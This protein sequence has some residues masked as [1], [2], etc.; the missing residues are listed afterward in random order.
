M[1]SREIVRG[2][3]WEMITTYTIKKYLRD[4]VY[5]GAACLLLAASQANAMLITFSDTYNP[6]PDPLIAFGNNSSYTFSHSLIADQDAGASLWSGTYGF[7]F[8]TDTITEAS[9]LMRFRDESADSAAES[10]SFFIDL[11][12]FGTQAITSGGDTSVLAINSGW[13]AI[14]EDGLLDITLSNAG[15][16]TGQQVN[17]SDFLFLDSTLSVRVNRGNEALSQVPEPTTLALF[18]L[19]CV[20]L[21]WTRL[22]PA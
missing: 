6:N 10:V 2:K 22:K 1:V 8:L 3:L 16:T 12:S 5:T 20:G 4:L 15:L 7:D 14:L 18:G 13:G 9:L 11:Q 17:R 19:G 21:L